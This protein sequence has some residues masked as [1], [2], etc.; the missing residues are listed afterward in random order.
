MNPQVIKLASI[1]KDLQV[2]PAHVRTGG[3]SKKKFSLLL[4]RTLESAKGA[5]SQKGH[6]ATKGAKPERG[7][8]EGFR[9]QLLSSGSPLKNLLLSR[10][11]VPGLKKLLLAEGFSDRQVND[12][13]EGLFAGDGRRVIKM[14]GLFEKLSELKTL[15]AKE[16][17]DPML[18]VSVLPYVETLLR[19]LGMDAREVDRAVSQATVRG[20]GLSLKGLIR[21]LKAIISKSPGGAR[22]GI[23][24]P[25]AEDIKGMLTRIGVVD[26]AGKINEPMSLERFVQMLEQKVASLMPHHL[27]KG[28]VENLV[29]RLLDHVSVAFDQQGTR[30][31]VQLYAGKGLKGL[32]KDSGI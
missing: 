18:E 2:E 15:S 6:E 30:P 5:P 26:E 20:E 4:D 17:S 25:S 1:L 11:A 27:Y 21:N 3:D 14:T 28:Q 16:P 32:S 8:L 24:Q 13:L 10:G 29:D 12:F 9:N 19:C 22:P 7:W 31:G 23:S